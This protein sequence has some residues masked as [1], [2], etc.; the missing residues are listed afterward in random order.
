MRRREDE[1][2]RELRRIRKENKQRL[3][4][5]S[6][7][8]STAPVAAPT[9][10]SSNDPS[11]KMMKIYDGDTGYELGVDIDAPT[12]VKDLIQQSVQTKGEDRERIT[13]R[14]KDRGK[15]DNSDIEPGSRDVNL[16]SEQKSSDSIPT[17]ETGNQVIKEEEFG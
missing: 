8:L 16:G 17:G 1:R 10:Y 2:L 14:M 9:Q 15:Y 7:M 4:N 13:Q 5:T 3:N 11:S 12:S 6:E